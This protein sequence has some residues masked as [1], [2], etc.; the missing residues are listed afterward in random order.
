[1][2]PKPFKYTKEISKKIQRKMSKVSILKFWAVKLIKKVF[3]GI[4]LHSWGPD[5]SFDTHI[6][7]SRHYKSGVSNASFMS[8]MPKMPYL[9]PMPSDICHILYGNM[10]VKRCARTL[11]MKI[12]AIKQ[13]FNKFNGSK[14]QN[15]DVQKFP[16]Y[17]L[18]FPL[19][20]VRG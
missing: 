2:P 12:N 13:F 18:K 5:A 15:T 6:A 20:N 9:T 7:I 3:N 4:S 11:G 17:F 19:Y 16:L 10:G 1:M 8:K 14:F